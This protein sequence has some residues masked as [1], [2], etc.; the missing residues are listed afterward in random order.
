MSESRLVNSAAQRYHPRYYLSMVFSAV[1][2]PP[3]RSVL[4]GQLR[5]QKPLLPPAKHHIQT[6]IRDKRLLFSLQTQG[7]FFQ[8]HP[9]KVSYCWTG[10]IW[11]FNW[12][13]EWNYQDC[14]RLIKM[15]PLN[16]SPK[17]KGTPTWNW[18]SVGEDEGWT[19]GS[20]L[21]SPTERQYESCFPSP[22]TK[23]S[24]NAY[25]S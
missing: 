10:H 6:T 19:D 21:I 2:S 14:L 12:H 18:D 4:W 5:L 8:K 22:P 11:T 17:G 25:Y 24:W 20:G 3:C 16:S 23:S 1:L 7:H 13:E 15:Y 9:C